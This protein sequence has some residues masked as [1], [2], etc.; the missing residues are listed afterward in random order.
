MVDGIFGPQ[1]KRKQQKEEVRRI[2]LPIVRLET[3]PRI[4]QEIASVVWFDAPKERAV[5]VGAKREDS[6]RCENRPPTSKHNKI[7]K[8]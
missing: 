8:S 1:N 5:P 4:R 2:Y 3:E 7:T 6:T